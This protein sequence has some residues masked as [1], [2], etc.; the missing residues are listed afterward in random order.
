MRYSN[1]IIAIVFFQC[2][3]FSSQA[4]NFNWT[5]PQQK[6]AVS[7]FVKPV[8]CEVRQFG[9]VCE[10]SIYAASH[11]YKG[12]KLCLF[13]MGKERSLWCGFLTLE[14]L[15]LL[16]TTS[17]TNQQYYITDGKQVLASTNFQVAIYQHVKQRKRRRYG[18][19]L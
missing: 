16:T 1:W 19:G 17:K 9:D 15:T 8:T 4:K 5:A 10:Y 3:A 7:L 2:L 14:P 11:R 6:P 18:L 12:K 13:Q